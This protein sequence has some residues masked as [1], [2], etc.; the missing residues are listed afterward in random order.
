MTAVGLNS[1]VTL[2]NQLPDSP[3]RQALAEMVA[4]HT[5]SK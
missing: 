4:R 3:L 1:L 5:V 2:A